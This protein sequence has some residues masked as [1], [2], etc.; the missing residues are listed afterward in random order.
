MVHEDL[1]IDE[2][3]IPHFGWHSCKQFLRAKPIRFC[4]KLWILASTTRL[5]YHV[6]IFEGKTDEFVDPLGT[7]VV[8]NALKV[9]QQ[10]N[11]HTV[12]FD[13]FFSSYQLLVNLNQ[14]GFRA[15]STMRKDCIMKCPLM[16]VKDMKKKKKKKKK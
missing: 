5:P 9:C 4:Y 7:R 8:K 6:E 14:M 11:T 15:T 10:R 12:Y 13:N 3:L 2:S 1:N 16:D